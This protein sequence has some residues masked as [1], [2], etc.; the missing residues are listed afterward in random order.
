MRAAI[1]PGQ[2][3]RVHVHCTRRQSMSRPLRTGPPSCILAHSWRIWACPH[4][5]SCDTAVADSVLPGSLGIA[6]RVEIAYI[7]S[8]SSG[9]QIHASSTERFDPL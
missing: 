6:T 4:Q 8:Y 5:Q 7:V 9:V 2:C 3:Q 1:S